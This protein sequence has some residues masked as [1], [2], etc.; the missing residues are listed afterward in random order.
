MHLLN[1]ESTILI[2]KLLNTILKIITKEKNTGFN[3]MTQQTE[4]KDTIL[5]PAGMTHQSSREKIAKWLNIPMRQCLEFK[6]T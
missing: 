4:K 3:I 5:L 2:L 1:M 6:M